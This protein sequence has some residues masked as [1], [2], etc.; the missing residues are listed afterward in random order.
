[1]QGRAYAGYLLPVIAISAMLFLLI[2]TL[3][4]LT[5]VHDQMRNN[6]QANM[7]W[8]LSRTQIKTLRLQASARQHDGSAQANEELVHH[9]T[10][11]LSRLH[12]LVEGPQQRFLKAIDTESELLAR[13]EAFLDTYQG[14]VQ[15]KVLG[16]GQLEILVAQLVIL[17][18]ELE[19]IS[20][21]VMFRQWEIDGRQLDGYR[22]TVLGAITLLVGILFCSLFISAKLLL[23]LK[24]TQAAHATELRSMELEARLISE[25]QVNGL[26]RHFASMMSHQFRTP[27]S[28]MDASLQRLLRTRGP[29]SREELTRRVG[30][31]REAIVR[32]TTV[33]DTLLTTDHPLETERLPSEAY[34][35]RLIAQRAIAIQQLTT[36]RARIEL[37]GGTDT[38]LAKC[39]PGMTEQILLNL[40]SNAVKY[41][42]PGKPV[43]VRVHEGGDMA[44]CDVTDAGGL[45]AENDIPELFKRHFRG[46]QASVAPGSGLGLNIAM[47]LAQLQEGRIQVGV[48]PG[49]HTTFTLMLP[50]ATVSDTPVTKGS[51][52]SD[53]T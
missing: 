42:P 7:T 34:E 23:T 37:K 6:D 44:C 35:L 26:Y 31:A 41:G 38:V 36:P 15:G 43:M 52:R 48:E 18:E 19:Q 14:A 46:V 49:K 27:L 2:L 21:K 13:T 33:L 53:D 3:S 17:Q 12:L 30:K 39:N 51:E 22:N 9:L 10:L 5:A 1:M 50:L 4:H 16:P 32:L 24:R 45:L 28:V 25:Q 11:L 20:R 29:L 40:L 47:Q 8:V